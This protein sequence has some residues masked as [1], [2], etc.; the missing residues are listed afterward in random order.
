[1]TTVTKRTFC[2]FCHAACP[3][4]V[5]VDTNGSGEETIT[6][7]RGDTADPIYGAYTCIKGRHLGD[8]H[9]NPERLRTALKRQ[10]DGSFVPMKTSDALDEIAEKLMAVM[11]A[12][13][14]RAMASYCG[15]ATF[16]NAAA[17]PI[18]RAFHKA[19]GSPSFYTSITIDQPAKM[20][21]PMR[22]GSWA[23]GPQPWS[24]ADVSL[25][26][27]SNMAVSM[28]GYPGGPTF[29]NPLASLRAA[30][31]RGLELI[32]IDPRRT[33]TA[34]MADI[35]L[36][37]IPG[38]DPALLGAMLKVILDEGLTDQQFCDRWV[39]GL[40]E[41]HATL[42]AFDLEWASA[43][44]GVAVDDIVAAARLFAKGPA[45]LDRSDPNRRV[46][47]YAISGTGPNMA[48]HGTLMEHLVACFNVIGG[49]Y[50]REGETVQCPTGI[51]SLNERPRA[52]KAQVNPPRPEMLTS[53]LKA[54]VRNLHTI[55]G[56]APT[57]ALADEILLP[58]EGQVRALL[59]VGG[60]PVLAWPDQQNVIAAL[61]DLEVHVALDIRVSATARLA[62]YVIPSVLSLERPDVPTNVDRWFEQPYV[63][64]TPTIV[65]PDPEMVDEAGLYV[66]LAKR[67][68][69][70]LELP[71]GEITPEMTP[72][73][74]DLL[75]L[76]YPHARVP[77]AELRAMDGAELR[78]T[79]TMVV[80]PADENASARFN[81]RPDGL[82]DELR[83]IRSSATSFET[84]TNFDPKVHTHRMA[85]RRL[86]AVFNSSGRELEVLR[87]KE[88]TSYAHM[89]PSELLTL[90][91]TDG[92]LV[93][94]TSTRATVR[95]PV[96]AAPDVRVGTISMAHSWGDLPGDHGPGSQ[97]HVLGDTTGKLTDVD[98]AYDPITGLPL[99]SAIPVSIRRAVSV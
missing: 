20:V 10:P 83:T 98:S 81:V 70:T 25:V 11:N 63:M 86:K 71:G 72:T 27:G 94:I 31:K 29:V 35:H 79:L 24:T 5:D 3:I 2:R 8:Q 26:V 56:Q 9:H 34:A 96:K 13:G 69:L 38:E 49:R 77:W 37:V 52:P 12:H 18:I 84:L 55:A 42:A 85:S 97:P 93:E 1:M 22:L 16:Q 4:E 82:L 76:S 73:P 7:V 91:L 14:P 89:H 87:K 66:E 58:G 57:S 6:A 32:V 21:M 60:N 43:R 15:T 50:P 95:V 61:N 75:E 19:T 59:T 47:G 67:M 28:F 17:H 30:K 33:E 45:S 44:C 74:D 36:Q 64:Y 92:D 68:G 80:E 78:D 41:L 40:D 53:G 46:K 65:E 90:G 88:T 51:L 54:R 48:P 39:E 99:M 62:D 23:A